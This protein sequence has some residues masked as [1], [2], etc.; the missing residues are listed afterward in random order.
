M[1][2]DLDKRTLIFLTSITIIITV[3]VLFIIEKPYINKG[4]DWVLTN[5]IE[6]K[7]SSNIAKYI[8]KENKLNKRLDI[9]ENKINV[10]SNNFND[11]LNKFDL[12]D[13]KINKLLNIFNKLN[14]TL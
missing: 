5:S 13:D 7:R 10:I 2:C 11:L 3:S 12:F 1:D 4:S 9:I 14:F 6:K 8:P